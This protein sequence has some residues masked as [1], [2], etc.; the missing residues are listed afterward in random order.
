MA[1]REKIPGHTQSPEAEKLRANAR[2]FHEVFSA[3]Q[4][5]ACLEAL[6]KVWASGPSCFMVV[7]GQAH[8]ASDRM[9]CFL[10]GRRAA[11]AEIRA[12]ARIGSEVQI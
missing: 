2:M 5:E 8:L 3:G 1:E 10:E 6:E 9:V 7:S 11:L 12:L 4:G